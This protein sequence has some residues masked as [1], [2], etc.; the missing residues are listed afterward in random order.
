MLLDKTV[1][2][3]LTSF[4]RYESDNN[5]ALSDSKEF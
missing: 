4:K 3:I 5:I 2:K 1:L